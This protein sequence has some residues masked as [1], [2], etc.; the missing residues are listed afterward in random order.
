MTVKSQHIA[1]L[2]YT[3]LSVFL[4]AIWHT[5]LTPFDEALEQLGV[6][7]LEENES[8]TFFVCFTANQEEYDYRLE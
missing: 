8:K 1:A 2:Q 3:I 5:M 6:M 7:F 4:V